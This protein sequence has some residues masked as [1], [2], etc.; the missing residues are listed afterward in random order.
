[1]PPV[2]EIVDSTAKCIAPREAVETILN[3]PFSQGVGG[4]IGTFGLAG[5]CSASNRIGDYLSETTGNGL[6]FEQFFGFNYD[7]LL[8]YDPNL[9]PIDVL[10]GTAPRSGAP[11]GGQGFAADMGG[12]ELP[13]S[14]HL[15]FNVG[16]QYTLFLDAFELTLRGDYYR[17]SGSYA[18]V[19]NTEY[20][21]LRGWDN[22]NLAITLENRDWDL[23]LQ[24][25]V[26][27]VFDNTPITDS[28]TNSDDTGLT[29]NVFT[30]DPRIIGFSIA[31]SF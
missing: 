20:D 13:N 5:L 4:G 24:A 27:N 9:S 7:P 25:Y 14:P 15:T 2:G 26:K 29:T 17:Q 22:A 16:A 1:V 18:R 30:L 19:Y 10:G 6:P 8:A 28:F 11:N 31:K 12:K 3:S 23:T 21:R